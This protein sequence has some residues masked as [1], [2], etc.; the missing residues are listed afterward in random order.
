MN[1]LV[2]VATGRLHRITLGVLVLLISRGTVPAQLPEPCKLPEHIQQDISTNPAVEKWGAVGGMFAQ[3]GQ[4]S[5]AVAAFREGLK[6]DPDSPEAN[7]NLGLALT[8][9]GSPKQAVKPL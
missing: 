2:A 9:T 4:M 3:R 6:L 7:F 1:A 5:C 8:Q